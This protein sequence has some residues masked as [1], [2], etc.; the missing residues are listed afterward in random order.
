MKAVK[1]CVFCGKPFVLRKGHFNQR[2][3]CVSC[4]MKARNKRVRERRFNQPSKIV[5]VSS[6]NRTS[7]AYCKD[8]WKQYKKFK[9]LMWTDE[10]AKVERQL[11]EQGCW[12]K[13]GL[14]LR[15][16]EKELAERKDKEVV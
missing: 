13:H 11:K 12:F 4:S 6:V 7:E 8:L 2:Y 3:C 1:N 15:K 5:T 10:Q 14:H 9:R 16:Y